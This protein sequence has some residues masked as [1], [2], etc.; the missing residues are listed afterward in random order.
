MTAAITVCIVR[1]QTSLEEVSELAKLSDPTDQDHFK[2]EMEQYYANSLGRNP[3][4]NVGIQYCLYDRHELIA[5]ARIKQ[6]DYTFEAVSIEY[7]AVREDMQKQGF[8][9]RLMSGLFE[10]IAV[11]WKKKYAIVVT[12]GDARSFYERIGMKL[13]G[14]FRTD[15]NI[16]RYHFSKSLS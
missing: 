1:P 7:I 13:F 6:D 8:G 10:E 12:T 15:E 11:H 14:V 4:L 2:W 5:V 3:S 16:P 9:R